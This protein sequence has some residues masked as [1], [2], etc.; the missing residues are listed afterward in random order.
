MLVIAQTSQAV[1]GP[2]R[3]TQAELV[4]GLKALAIYLIFFSLFHIG[5]FGT[6][7]ALLFLITG[8][9]YAYLVRGQLRAAL[10]TAWPVLLFPGLAVLSVL[11]S[12]APMVTLRA[13]IQLILTG[14]V[15]VLLVR[16]TRSRSI[17]LGLFWAGLTFNVG[18]L[19]F[20]LPAITTGVPNIGLTGELGSKNMMAI[21][22][23]TATIVAFA[24][25][26]D[27]HEKKLIRLWALFGTA[28]GAL[29]VVSAYSAGGTIATLIAIAFLLAF[30]LLAVSRGIVRN[31]LVAGSILC[32]PLLVAAAP[33]IQ[34]AAHTVQTQVLKKSEDI[35]GRGYLWERAGELINERPFEGRGYYAYWRRDN[36]DAEGIR[37]R[38]GAMGGTGFNFHNQ[39]LDVFVDLGFL[40]VFIFVGMIVATAAGLMLRLLTAPSPSL[41]LFAA[42]FVSILARTPVESFVFYPFYPLTVL[43]FGACTVALAGPSLQSAAGPRPR[44]Q[45]GR[46]ASR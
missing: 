37:R 42:L 1:P 34:E 45:P 19:F 30:R 10:Q 3:F 12:E 24:L 17:F 26:T 27:R 33:V 14:G 25:A 11:W 44:P 7:G 15:G 35:S 38:F 39:Y 13:A 20:G 18:S 16:T 31:V 41:P 4:E 43:F 32:A 23:S 40:G 9:A 28:A 29:A 36:L 46:L 6:M 2:R 22:A 5:L 21:F 8:G